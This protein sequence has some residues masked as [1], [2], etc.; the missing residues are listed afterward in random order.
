MEEIND[1]SHVRVVSPSAITMHHT[2]LD[3][4]PERPLSIN[5]V[6]LSQHSPEEIID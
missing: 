4:L 3:R 5:I 2:V 6:D 1:A